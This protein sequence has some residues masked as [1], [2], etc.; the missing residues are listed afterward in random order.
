M[1]AVA[2]KRLHRLFYEHTLPNSVGATVDLDPEESKHAA[3]VLRLPVDTE[4][5][6]CN[7][8]GEIVTGRITGANKNAISVTTTA[9]VQVVRLCVKCM[10]YKLI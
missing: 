7:G 6:V 8:C 3:R 5:E 1:Q 2:S 4:V 10:C 9:A